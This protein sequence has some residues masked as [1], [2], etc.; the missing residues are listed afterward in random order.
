MKGGGHQG[1]GIFIAVSFSMRTFHQLIQRHIQC[2]G[3]YDGQVGRTAF[4]D[5]FFIGGIGIEVLRIGRKES[6]HFFSGTPVL[7]DIG[8]LAGAAVL[9]IYRCRVGSEADTGQQ[10]ENQ[11]HCHQNSNTFFE[12]AIHHNNSS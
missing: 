1:F 5:Q 11:Q 3:I 10:A 2:A 6:C 12:Q 4:G 7:N 9:I 8:I